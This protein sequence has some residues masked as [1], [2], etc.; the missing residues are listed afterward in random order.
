MPRNRIDWLRQAFIAF[1]SACIDQDHL[2][3]SEIAYDVPCADPE[4]L[5]S[6]GKTNRRR[7]SN[8]CGNR[9]SSFDPAFPT[10]VEHCHALV[11]EPAQHPPQPSRRGASDVVVG[12]HLP[13]GVDAVATEPLHEYL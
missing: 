6:A 13:A 5:R 4:A 1:C 12:H 8:S 7:Y 2:F 3:G 11:A 9:L 10:A